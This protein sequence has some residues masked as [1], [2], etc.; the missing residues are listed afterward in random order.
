MK[1]KPKTIEEAE[2]ISVRRLVRVLEKLKLHSE[3]RCG[4]DKLRDMFNAITGL[5][6]VNEH[7]IERVLA[8]GAPRV[9]SMGH[10]SRFDA[11]LG[12]VA[13]SGVVARSAMLA[14][15]GLR[16]LSTIDSASRTNCF[17][18]TIE[19]ARAR[20]TLA[21]I[22]KDLNFDGIAFYEPEKIR[23][24]ALA[25][26]ARAFESTFH[27]FGYIP[28]AELKAAREKAANTKRL[29]SH[30]GFLPVNI[31]PVHPGEGEAR[32]WGEYAAKPPCAEKNLVVARKGAK[33]F[34]VRSNRLGL[35]ST[36]RMFELLSYLTVRDLVV[37]RGPNGQRWKRD[38]FAYLGPI[39]SQHPV[40]LLNHAELDIFW[41]AYWLECG[42]RLFAANR[43]VVIR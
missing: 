10:A 1:K 16:T 5:D 20:Q 35:A 40:P 11:L 33:P 24:G 43:V 32:G 27:G 41:R 23:G 2:A 7:E 14:S 22:A 37:A 3:K 17:E 6:C 4:K 38:L 9:A 13:A 26:G 19:F 21:N 34:K 15:N 25:A 29:V 31:K 28:P 39:G 18:P 8:S 36:V 30:E 42:N 12:T